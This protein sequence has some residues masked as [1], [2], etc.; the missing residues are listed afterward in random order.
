MNAFDPVIIAY[1]KAVCSVNALPASDP[2]SFEHVSSATTGNHFGQRH[3]LPEHLPAGKSLSSSGSCIAMYLYGVRAHLPQMAC[4][5]LLSLR[6]GDYNSPWNGSLPPM[7]RDAYERSFVTQRTAVRAMN[8]AGAQARLP[9]LGRWTT[10]GFWAPAYSRHPCPAFASRSARTIIVYVLARWLDGFRAYA[11]A[12]IRG[13]S[14]LH[15]VQHGPHVDLWLAQ[16]SCVVESQFFRHTGRTQSTH[17][18]T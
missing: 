8:R 5:D 10:R 3:K 13:I 12:R 14:S 15:H 1:R 6:I 7:F 2:R 17:F 11:R 9:G 18:L 16:G 4:Y